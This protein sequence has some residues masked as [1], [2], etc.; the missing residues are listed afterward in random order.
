MVIP[1]DSY[2]KTSDQKVEDVINNA[3][4]EFEKNNPKIK[5]KLD[6]STLLPSYNDLVANKMIASDDLDI[7]MID[8]QNLMNFYNTEL[9][10]TFNDLDTS[11]FYQSS[12][13]SCLVDDNLIALPFLSDLKVMVLDKS[14][15]NKY[16]IAE[17]D[18][19][20]VNNFIEILKKLK[21]NNVISLE[22]F[23]YPTV[24]ALYNTSLV[25]NGEIDVDNQKMLDALRL[26][27]NLDYYQ[28]IDNIDIVSD[29]P[30]ISSS[31][32]LETVQNINTSIVAYPFTDYQAVSKNV[33]LAVSAKSKNSKAALKFT[34]FLASSQVVQ[35]ELVDKKVSLSSLKAI[36]QK[37]IN[38]LFENSSTITYYPNYDL[39]NDYF[40]LNKDNLDNNN[41]E[42]ELAIINRNLKKY[43]GK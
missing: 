11:I 5:I 40:S 2:F 36:D 22:S 35:Q 29:N 38:S 21:R 12:L 30:A 3:I 33:Y 27:L 13:T 39:I 31:F 16:N 7:F 24:F 28:N 43:L 10:K 26:Y 34:T 9:L 32:Y 42:I 4:K 37:E 17:Q 1:A 6:S 20:G 19:K 23:D 18:L 25:R 41:L 15:L 8:D 14:L